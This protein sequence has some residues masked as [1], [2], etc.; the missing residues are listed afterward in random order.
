MPDLK[1][2][3]LHPAGS[4]ELLN[5]FKEWSTKAV[6]AP[7]GVGRLTLGFGVVPGK[8]NALKHLKMCQTPANRRSSL[9]P[10]WGLSL[11]MCCY[12]ETLWL[13]NHRPLVPQRASPSLLIC[14][15]EPPSAQRF[16]SI[17]LLL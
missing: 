10:R 15:Y 2:L 7:W 5:T 3:D 16:W 6:S 12:T 8:Q 14:C 11:V 13:A 4:Q 9:R 1:Q 17:F